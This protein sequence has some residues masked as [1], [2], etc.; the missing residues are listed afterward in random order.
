MLLDALER[1]YNMLDSIDIW[2]VNACS[3]SIEKVEY[4]AEFAQRDVPFEP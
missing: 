1:L 4:N 2:I 3:I